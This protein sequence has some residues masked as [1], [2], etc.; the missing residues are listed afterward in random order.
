MG[1]IQQHHGMRRKPFD[2]NRIQIGQRMHLAKRNNRRQFKNRHE[3]QITRQLKVIRQGNVD[4]GL[5]QQTEQFRLVSLNL[6]DADVIM[7]FDEAAAKAGQDH[8]RECAKATDSQ[9]SPDRSRQIPSQIAQCGCLAQDQLRMIK[10]FL[11]GQCR[12]Q[13]LGVMTHKKPDAKLVFK[14]RYP[15]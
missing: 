1:Q 10:Q 6:G 12:C 7:L 2:R 9:R 4:L 15:G 8:L 11:S 3:L 14:L 13:P 5:P